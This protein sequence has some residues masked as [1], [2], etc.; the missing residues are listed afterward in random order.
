L[1][2]ANATKKKASAPSAADAELEGYRDDATLTKVVDR[3]WYERNKHIYPASIWEEFDP[4]KD[5]SKGVR[6]DTEGN[7]F[8]FS[9]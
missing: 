1:S 5:Y 7:A 9:S 3:R 4:G 8:F 6:K 2:R